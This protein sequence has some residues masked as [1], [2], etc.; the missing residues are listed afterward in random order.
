[1]LKTFRFLLLSLLFAGTA[2]AA[3]APFDAA[4]FDALNKEGKPILVAI[5]A[6][7]CPTCKAQDPIV[8]ELLKMPA[9]QG[10]TTLRVDF[11]KQKDIVKRFKVQYQS[12]LIV[13]KDGKE[14]GRSTGDTNKDSIAALLKKAL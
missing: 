6:D 3:G 8:S 14:V 1:M 9:L 12:T 13:F 4:K 2:L 7:W 5:H 11:D 10:I